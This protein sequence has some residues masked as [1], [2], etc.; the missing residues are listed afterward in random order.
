[1]H[2][3]KA[4]ATFVDKFPK[5]P[6]TSVECSPGI[7]ASPSAAPCVGIGTRGQPSSQEED[8]EL[9]HCNLLSDRQVVLSFPELMFPTTESFVGR[10]LDQLHRNSELRSQA[11]VLLNTC[12]AA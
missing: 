5:F 4:Q 9:A 10:P 2:Y 6:P 7:A 1:M 8:I 11:V 12:T 3:L